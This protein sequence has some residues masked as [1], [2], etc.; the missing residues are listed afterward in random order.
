M[1]RAHVYTPS[2]LL[3]GEGHFLRQHGF[4][5]WMSADLIQTATDVLKNLRLVA[6]YAECSP[7]NSQ[8][9]YLLW[10]PPEGCGIEIRSGRTKAQF[11]Q[12]DN[13]NLERGWLLLSLHINERDLYSAVWIS[14]EH[15]KTASRFLA[16]Y[17]ITP[18]SQMLVT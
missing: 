15:L 7:D 1:K 17:G 12:Y 4:T 10:H 6:I 8:H 2:K 5:R 18:A 14:P 16:S 13:D 11:D 9:R 3:P